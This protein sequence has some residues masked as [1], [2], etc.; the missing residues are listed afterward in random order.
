MKE[1]L[2]V[3]HMKAFKI[4]TSRFIMPYK[5][6]VDEINTKINILKEEF[7]HLHDY[8]PI[9][10]I[11]SRVKTVESILKK[12][13]RRDL[14]LTIPDIKENIQDIAGVRV[15]CSFV[16]DIYNIQKM[17]ETQEDIEVLMVKDY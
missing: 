9:E 14:S 11:S 4:E 1:K 16:S 15:T 10:H 3:H 2:S 12:A 5:F 7:T 17:I 8:N 6:A 13:K